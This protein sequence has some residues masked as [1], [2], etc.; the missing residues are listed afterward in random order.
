[1][2]PTAT[3]NSSPCSICG[4]PIPEATYKGQLTKC[5][6]CNSINEAITQVTIPSAILIGVFS[7]IAGTLF[8]HAILV[9]ARGE[10]ERLI[11]KVEERYKK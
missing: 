4:Y 5:P 8:G 10:S 9:S 2:P 6:Y 11:R 7:F 3:L 1:M